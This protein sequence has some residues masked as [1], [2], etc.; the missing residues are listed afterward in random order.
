MKGRFA[1]RNVKLMPI[2]AI[3]VIAVVIVAALF[4]GCSQQKAEIEKQKEII[5]R[6]IEEAWN[7]GNVS[8]L[9]EHIADDFIRHSP[10]HPDVKGLD[11]LKEYITNTHKYYSKFHTTIEEILVDGN[12]TLTRFT[13]NAVRQGDNMEVTSTGTSVD[14]WENGKDIERWVHVDMLGM[15]QQLG[16]KMIPPITDSTFARVTITQT[17]PEKREEA[18]KIYRESVVPDAKKQKGFRAIYS[19]SDFKTGK[20]ISISIWDSEADALANE[21]SGYYKAQVDRFKDLF[22]SRPVREGYVVTVQE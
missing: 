5:Q 10:P 17:K 3:L 7:K 11:G 20:G 22:T 2:M 8:V 12:S 4:I 15:F 19:L 13:I 6:E 16:Y 1:M 18:V 9:D 14:H 21:Q